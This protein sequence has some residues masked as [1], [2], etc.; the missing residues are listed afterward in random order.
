MDDNN[1]KQEAI[2]VGRS[3]PGWT[4]SRCFLPQVPGAEPGVLQ[5]R[6]ELGAQQDPIGSTGVGWVHPAASVPTTYPPT[7]ARLLFS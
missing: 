6:R 7:A 5:L 3:S 1:R 4:L 2:S